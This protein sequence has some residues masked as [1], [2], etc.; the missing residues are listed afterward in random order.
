MMAGY[1]PAI[2]RNRDNAAAFERCHGQHL[3]RRVLLHL[4]ASFDHFD[5]VELRR[6]E[7]VEFL[8]FADNEAKRIDGVAAMY[9]EDRRTIGLLDDIES[10]AAPSSSAARQRTA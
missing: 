10:L 8:Q 3:I 5:L 2:D 7:A 6:H 9:V 1:D 4:F